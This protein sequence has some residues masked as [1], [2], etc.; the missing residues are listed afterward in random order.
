MS[1][2]YVVKTLGLRTGEAISGTSSHIRF[3]RAPEA[4]ILRAYFRSKLKPAAF[5]AKRLPDFS[6]SRRKE[7]TKVYLISYFKKKYNKSW[8]G[9]EHICQKLGLELKEAQHGSRYRHVYL[10][11]EEAKTLIRYL[12]SKD[13]LSDFAEKLEEKRA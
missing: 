11:G 2:T 10:E 4:E 9:I 12:K 6:Q 13:K 8:S 7:F 1:T 3:L 5:K